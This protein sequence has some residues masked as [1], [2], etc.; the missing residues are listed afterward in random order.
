M[1]VIGGEDLYE[2][3]VRLFGDKFDVVRIPPESIT[4]QKP[5]ENSLEAFFDE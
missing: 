1:A 2:M 3:C 4:E 5:Q